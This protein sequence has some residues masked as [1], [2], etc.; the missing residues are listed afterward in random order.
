MCFMSQ[1]SANVYTLNAIRVIQGQVGS[2]ELA[3]LRQEY[4]GPNQ[5]IDDVDPEYR[6]QLR[7]ILSS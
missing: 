4:L 7:Q 6:E 3:F 1:L 2:S 5:C